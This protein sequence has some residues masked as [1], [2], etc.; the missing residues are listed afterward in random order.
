MFEFLLY[1]KVILDYLYLFKFVF[2]IEWCYY[3][4]DLAL[5]IIITKM[6]GFCMAI[7]INR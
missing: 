4:Q 7:R 1:Q 6:I 5:F 3:F 2:K